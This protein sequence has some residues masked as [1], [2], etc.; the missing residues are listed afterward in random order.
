MNMC[1]LN[2]VGMVYSHILRKGVHNNTRNIQFFLNYSRDIHPEIFS[3]ERKTEFLH[4]LSKSPVIWGGKPSAVKNAAI[5]VPLCTSNS[6]PS[7]LFTLR[8]PNIRR[9]RGQVSFPGGMTDKTDKDFI[10]TA[11]RE[12]KEEIGI[13]PSKITVWGEMK[14]LPT[15]DEGALV[16]PVVAHIGEINPRDLKIN[17]QE[18]ELIFTRTIQSLC[19]PKNWRVTQMRFKYGYTVPVF[20]GGEHRIW[21]LTAVCL[22]TLLLSL[23]P[24]VYN[25]NLHHHGMLKV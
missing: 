20:L 19:D 13:A 17:P 18:V 14:P 22:H 25:F 21:G 15:R 24:E 12:T 6:I 3:D 8:S 9:H 23:V 1:I 2:S 4:R 16:V 7:V 11:I 5:L 10:H